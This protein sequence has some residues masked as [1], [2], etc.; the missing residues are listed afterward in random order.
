MS[1]S[2]DLKN[3][4]LEADLS[5]TKVRVVL[6]PDETQTYTFD[7]PAGS[8]QK[9]VTWRSID[10]FGWPFALK[11]VPKD[12]YYSHSVD[13]ELHKVRELGARFAQLRFYGE[14]HL[15]KPGYEFLTN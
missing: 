1:A 2:N 13:S 7:R 15:E 3:R 11:F 8:G 4:L 6:S 10:R 14:P 5:G 9:A 12:E